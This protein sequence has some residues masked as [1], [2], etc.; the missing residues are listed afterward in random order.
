[1]KPAA[2]H[3]TTGGVQSIQRSIKAIGAPVEWKGA[4]LHLLFPQNSLK[5]AQE[6]TQ[7]LEALWNS[8]IIWTLSSS[9]K[10][11]SF[12]PY[13]S[14][15]DSSEVRILLILRIRFFYQHRT[16]LL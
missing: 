16:P 12:P 4:A 14:L 7:R 15:I 6:V 13:Q 5:L 8:R 3:L 2:A 9:I 1:M 11:L 10:A